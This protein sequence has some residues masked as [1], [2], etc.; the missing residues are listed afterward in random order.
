VTKP[1]WP[2]GDLDEAAM[3]IISNVDWDAQTPE[4]QAAAR[5]WLD[6]YQDQLRRDR[7]L[8]Q[9]VES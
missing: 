9:A 6:A 1:D 4:W 5:A 8:R 3:G 7:Q 2:A